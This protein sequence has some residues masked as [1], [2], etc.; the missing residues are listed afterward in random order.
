MI[1]QVALLF[2]SPAGQACPPP[3]IAGPGAQLTALIR[4]LPAPVLVLRHPWYA[5]QSGRGTF[6]KGEGITDVL[7]S[8][9]PKGRRALRADLRG[10]LDRDHINAVVL[11][12]GFDTTVLGARFGQ[13]FRLA[14]TIPAGARLYPLTD[15]RT[16]PSLIYIRR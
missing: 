10:A 2:Q 9:A 4:R 12:G 14:Q 5:A 7:R 6:T 11:D 16:A 3:A 15:T 8:A 1:V 13:E